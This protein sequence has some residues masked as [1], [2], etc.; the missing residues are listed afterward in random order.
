MSESEEKKSVIAVFPGSF[1]P[2]T[3]G[4]FSIAE[5]AA[6]LFSPLYIAIGINESKI[7]SGELN[8]RLDNI[9]KATSNLEGVKVV[10]YTGLTADLCKELGAEVIVRGVRSVTDFE[11]E[12]N[13]ADV[14]RRLAGI[15]TVLLYSLPE[16]SAVSSS[17]VR[18]LRHFGVDTTEFLP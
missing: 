14:N 4:H 10:A 11:Y 16:L 2:F 6:K 8:E 18:E 12:R 17:L 3:K 13:M 7:S 1:D 9:R 15:E 5:R